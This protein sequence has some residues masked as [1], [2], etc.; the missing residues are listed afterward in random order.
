MYI[1][2]R[3]ES[4]SNL[5][6]AEKSDWQLCGRVRRRT[7]ENGLEKLPQSRESASPHLRI[8][9]ESTQSPYA[10]SSPVPAIFWTND[11]RGYTDRRGSLD[12]ADGRSKPKANGLF[13]QVEM[14]LDDLSAMQLSD[15]DKR[16]LFER[17]N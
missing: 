15:V 8:S 11:V 4:E 5:I 17:H 9:A 14:P 13:G 1:A 3:K 6:L 2:T 7:A 12:A 10:F 16:R